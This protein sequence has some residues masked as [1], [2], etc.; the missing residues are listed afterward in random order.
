M[1]TAR[2]TTGRKDGIGTAIEDS[3]RV[4]FTTVGSTLTEVFYPSPDQACTRL[5]ELVVTDGAGFVSSAGVDLVPLPVP[6]EDQAPVIASRG[7]CTQGRYDLE[8]ETIADPVSDVVVQ[9]VRFRPRAGETL[10]L[11][12]VLEPHLGNRGD[13]NVATILHH[14]GVLM[15]AAARGD[16]LALALAC[17]APMLAATAGY[18]GDDGRTQLEITGALATAT[19]HA[20]PGT[21]SV[22]GE[23]DT[24]TGDLVLALGFART[25]TAAAH[26]AHDALLRGYARSRTHFIAG[27]HAWHAS[28]AYAMPDPPPLWKR[29]ATILKTLEAKHPDAGRVAALATP[30]GD[31]RGSG[32]DG[33]Y[34]LIW[35]RDLVESVGA[36]LAFGARHEPMRA[37]H[38]LRSTQ[39]PDGHWPQNMRL[40]GTQVWNNN[41]LDE[42]ALPLV[43][44]HLVERDAL[45][46]RGELAGFWPMLRAAAGYIARHGPTTTRDRWEDT[47]GVTPFTLA[48]SIVALLVASELADVHGEPLAASV[49]RDLADQWNASIERWLYRRGGAL[50]ERLGIP[51]YYVRARGLGEPF[52]ELDLA[53]LPATE[54]SPD[55]LALVRFGLRAADDPRIA[56]TVRAIDA[57]LRVELPGGPA[58]RRYPGDRY[59]E[60]R[61]G[62]AFSSDGESIGR[63]WPLLTGERGHYELARGNVDGARAM[64]RAMESFATASGN[65]P[66]QVWD[67]PDLPAQGLYFGRPTGSAA[68]LG[69]THGEYAKLAR[70][71]R[72]GRIFDLPRHA[73]E[74]Y[75]ARQTPPRITTWRVGEPV[76]PFSGAL[77]VACAAPAIVSWRDAA[78]GATRSIATVDTGLGLHVADFAGDALWLQIHHHVSRDGDGDELAFVASR[79][80]TRS[81]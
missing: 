45:V 51:G 47:G 14:K 3:S 18:L 23:L 40:D 75:I 2:W 6:R 69:W 42:V 35:T 19:E 31:Q 22:V 41:E 65:L 46:D 67:G 16:G 1:A 4:W 9:R 43:F 12:C 39:E 38:Y 55:A 70:S 49:L 54:L 72:E 29:S 48:T 53:A 21:V 80:E 61:D 60:H 5:L 44:L 79:S 78:G 26:H 15:L 57:T 20:G 28:L 64:L 37:L 71:M 27:W 8:L 73:A 74:R 13:D 50:A 36:L 81:S 56:D 68:P 34:H 24:R 63:P 7:R 25:T 59:G 11:F 52:A 10:R 32:S 77:R 62:T 33:T 30:W 66:E 17:S 58:W 76:I